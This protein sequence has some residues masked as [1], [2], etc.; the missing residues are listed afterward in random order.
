MN[1]DWQSLRT[2]I[3][4]FL[5]WKCCLCPLQ[6]ESSG[7]AGPA[8]HPAPL[9]GGCLGLMSSQACLRV[10]SLRMC[11]EKLPCTAHPEPLPWL[12]S[13]GWCWRCQHSWATGE[14]S[15]VN[16]SGSLLWH[17]FC[18]TSEQIYW[19]LLYLWK[20]ENESFLTAC[21]AQIKLNS[22]PQAYTSTKTSE[23]MS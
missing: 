10:T 1:C 8:L 20:Q 13:K 15:S 14:T 4:L 19:V 11:S 21:I 3:Q 7:K 6:C 16:S 2:E 18:L 23:K 12:C 22:E 5:G 17:L 9:A